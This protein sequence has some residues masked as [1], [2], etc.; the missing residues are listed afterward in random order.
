MD[1]IVDTFEKHIRKLTYILNDDYDSIYNELSKNN[2]IWVKATI[3][4]NINHEKQWNDLSQL[5]KV[6]VLNLYPKEKLE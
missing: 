2:K 3:D 5:E 1:N 4:R 6:K